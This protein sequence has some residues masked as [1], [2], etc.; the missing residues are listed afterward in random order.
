M[1]RALAVF[2]GLVALVC[3]LRLGVHATLSPRATGV[4]ATA[5]AMGSALAFVATGPRPL[6]EVLRRCD[7][8]WVFGGGVLLGLPWLGASGLIDPWETHYA[9]VAREMI[10]RGDWLSPWWANEGWFRTKPVLIFWLEAAAMR[11]LGV[12]TGPNE[13]LAGGAHP[14]WAVRLPA[15]AFAL[16]GSMVLYDGVRRTCGRRA[17]L[18]G[19]LAL[20]TMPG[21]LLL[22]QQAI[23]DMPLVAGIAAALGLLLRALSTSDAELAATMRVGRIELHFG[24]LVAVV[25]ALLG[26]GQIAILLAAQLRFAGGLHL[27]SDRLFLGSPHACGLPGQPECVVQAVA[28]RQL[29]PIAQAC[30]WATPLAFAVRSAATERRAARLFALAAWIAASLATMAKGPAG[31]VLPAAAVLADALGRRSLAKVW[32]LELPRGLAIAFLLVGPWYLAMVARH[33]RAFVD[34]LVFRHMLGRTLEHL[35]DTNGSEDVGVVYFVRQLG[36]AMFPWS[37]IAALGFF[38]GGDEPGRRGH[39]RTF[40]FGAALAAFA[41]VSMMRTKFHH[42]GLV[43]LPPLAM[44]GGVW[45]ADARRGRYT[46][47][48]F[49]AAVTLLVGRDLERTPAALVRLLTYRYDRLWPSVAPLAPLFG[50]LAIVACVLLVLAHAATLRRWSGRLAFALAGAFALTLT[51][52]YLPRAARDGGQRELLA[53]YTA[54]RTAGPLVAYQLNW[55]GENFYSGNDVAIFV[56]SGPPFRKYVDERRGDVLWLVTERARVRAMQREIGPLRSFREIASNAEYT[57]VRVEL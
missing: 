34:E 3:V 13:L 31:L 24:H 6:A 47:A 9:E 53:R 49:A 26:L 5:I 32:R 4:L 30:L 41:L 36:Y 46:G 43:A 55:K 33:G 10:E 19:G 25:I 22:S 27:V 50:A 29:T 56:A 7:A 8:L 39:A 44:L 15:F 21:Y 11:F 17:A 16:L 38:G 37:G 51:T 18:F 20:W 14:E 12:R 28:H 40:L 48:L 54:E 42:Y 45:L 1:K 23:T 57:L 52:S 2:V 35:H